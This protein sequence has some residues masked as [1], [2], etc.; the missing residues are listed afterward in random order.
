MV[1]PKKRESSKV[2]GRL[3]ASLK[4]A[5]VPTM[6]HFGGL[7]NGHIHI[8]PR[9]CAIPRKHKAMSNVSTSASV[10]RALLAIDSLNITPDAPVT[11]KS[12]IHAPVYI[13]NRRLIFFPAQWHVII[14]ACLSWLHSGYF[15]AD[16]IAGVETSGIPHSSAFAFNARLPSVFVRKQAKGHGLKQRVEGGNVEN[17][18]VLLVEDMVS[19]GES[20]L[21]AIDALRDS[22][23]VVT[24]CLAII[25]YGFPDTFARFDAAGVRLHTLT[26]FTTLL[27]EATRAGKLSPDHETIIRT[28]WANPHEWRAS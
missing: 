17:Q 24:D 13:D 25:T 23:A 28:W 8:I 5:D 1:Y 22:G 10:A 18:R 3:Y 20:S 15:T 12:G 11:F 14:E 26:T 9:L 16:V 21:S 7:R 2:K 4:N 27:E 19:T 6:W